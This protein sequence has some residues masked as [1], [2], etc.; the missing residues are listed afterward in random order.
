ML[1]E[2]YTDAGSEQASI[3]LNGM[4]EGHSGMDIVGFEDWGT[5]VKPGLFQNV[6][7]MEE[8]AARHAG[9]H[10]SREKRCRKSE[11]NMGFD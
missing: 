1:F 2:A 5:E 10:G 8:A 3:C 7:H 9:N 11:R 4:T 6:V